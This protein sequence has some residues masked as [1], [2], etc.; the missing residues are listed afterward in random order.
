MRARTELR[1]AIADQVDENGEAKNRKR[2][3]RL[4]AKAVSIMDIVE[5]IEDEVVAEVDIED[6]VMVETV[7]LEDGAGTAAVTTRP[8]RN[9]CSLATNDLNDK[10]GSLW[11]CIKS[12]LGR[13]FFI[14]EKL[15]I[16]NAVILALGER[17]LAPK[18]R[19]TGKMDGWMCLSSYFFALVS[20]PCAVVSPGSRLDRMRIMT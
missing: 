15:R 12:L 14:F 5:V 6:E 8:L 13:R 16:S 4:L 9:N 11:C 10:R 20:F 18:M 7:S 19:N 17:L 1:R 3:L 2:M